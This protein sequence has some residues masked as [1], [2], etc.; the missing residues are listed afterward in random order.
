MAGTTKGAAVPIRDLIFFFVDRETA[1]ELIRM[2]VVYVHLI[3]CCVA[4]GLILTSDLAVIGQ[5]MRGN[6]AD[7][8]TEGHLGFLKKNVALALGV[9]WITGITIVVLDASMKGW[10]YFLNPKLQVKIAIVS[11]LTVNGVLLDRVVLPVLNRAGTLLKLAAGTRQ[12]ALFAGTVSAV[13]WF[14]AAML[15][16]GRPLAWKYS[17]SELMLAYPLLI[18]CGYGAMSLLVRQAENRRADADMERQHL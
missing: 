3:A 12:I 9:L 14:Y 5:L 7:H 6:A 18:I 8:F 11:L 10:G 4:I 13:S 17:F 16:V 1:M 2:G 15:G